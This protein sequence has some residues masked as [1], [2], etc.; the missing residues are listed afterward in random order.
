MVT[1]FTRLCW[2]LYT[3]RDRVDSGSYFALTDAPITFAAT[4]LKS[5]NQLFV[6]TKKHVA[7]ARLVGQ[8][9]DS[10]DDGRT[11]QQ[12]GAAQH[13]RRPYLRIRKNHAIGSGDPGIEILIADERLHQVNAVVPLSESS[14]LVQISLVFGVGD[15]HGADDEKFGIWQVR[16]DE[17]LDGAIEALMPLDEANAQRTVFAAPVT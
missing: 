8:P 7:P 12:L 4:S 6:R 2:R 5:G 15:P 1:V 13:R 3:A 11:V 17:R 14:Q 16:L 9:A 10:R